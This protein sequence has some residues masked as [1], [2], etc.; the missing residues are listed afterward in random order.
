MEGESRNNTGQSK[1]N[2]HSMQELLSV[3]ASQL[4]NDSEDEDDASSNM[5]RNEAMPIRG[6]GLGECAQPVIGQPSD[7]LKQSSLETGATSGEDKTDTL[8][9]PKPMA[10]LSNVNGDFRQSLDVGANQINNRPVPVQSNNM[11][12]DAQSLLQLSK[13]PINKESSIVAVGT[14]PAS[15][16]RL[17]DLINAVSKNEEAVGVVKSSEVPV[18]KG[19]PSTPLS[20]GSQ[21]QSATPTESPAMKKP[22]KK[23][24]PL[25]KDQVNYLKNWLF[26]PHH[27]L[28]PYPTDEE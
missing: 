21:D 10:P 23:V 5:S 25:S 7:M 27:I 22:K 9:P 15:P 2:E 14:T 19:T 6:G 8:F 11:G 12:E 17:Q 13:A 18:P 26:D 3:K 4:N 20:V 28:N 24:V 1:P 16:S